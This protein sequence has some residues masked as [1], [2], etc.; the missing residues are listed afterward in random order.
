[1]K[2]FHL[3]DSGGFFGAERVLLTLAKQQKLHGYDVAIVSYGAH[4]QS[5]KAIEVECEK[6]G[7]SLIKWRGR[8]LSNLIKL[9]KDNGQAIFHSHGYKFNILLAVVA[10]F[11]RNMIAVSTVHGYTDAP[12]YSKLWVYYCVNRLALRVLKGNVFVSANSAF[13]SKIKLSESN[14]VIY[15][16]ISAFHATDKSVPCLANELEYLIAV[17]RL[18][19]EKAFNNL[20]L[21]FNRIS[22]KYKKLSLVIVGDGPERSKLVSMAEGRSDVIFMGQINDPIPII[23]GARAVVISSISEGLPIVLLEAMRAGKDIVSTK[24]GAIPQVIS[25]GK[26]GILCEPD[27]YIAL[28]EAIDAALKYPKGKLGAL[29]KHCF[30]E[31][32]T[33]QKMFMQY[34][35]WYQKLVKYK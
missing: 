17:G 34:H 7:L 19:A 11:F 26:N 32:Y 28:A 12:R 8:P 22:I 33:D 6:L 30:K 23:E 25:N 10:I 4:Y 3:I 2:V 35:E 31:N 21:A 9:I 13:M 1:M 5:V 29:A 16:G 27:D 18:S 24:V 14:I 20:I 15:N